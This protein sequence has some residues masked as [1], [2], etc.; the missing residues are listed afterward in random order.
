MLK[1]WD[2]S[3]TDRNHMAE[4]L[5]ADTIF[6]GEREID[7]PYVNFHHLFFDVKVPIHHSGENYD[8]PLCDESLHV[9]TAVDRSV[10]FHHAE[11]MSEHPQKPTSHPKTRS[12]AHSQ[13]QTHLP[14]IGQTAHQH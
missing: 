3:T 4:K 9:L 1:H 12:Y 14:N 13:Q 5:L 10:F 7:R 8:V 2:V 11:K 6:Y